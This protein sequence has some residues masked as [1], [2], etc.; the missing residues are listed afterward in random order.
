MEHNVVEIDSR[1]IREKPSTR[2][3]ARLSA[4]R[5]A[6]VEHAAHDAVVRGA[7]E[8]K[9]AELLSLQLVELCREA[10]ALK[11][12]RMHATDARE[13]Q[14]LSTR[15][16]R[17][18]RTIAAATVE[19]HRLENGEPSPAVVAKVLADLQQLVE[20]CMVELFPGDTAERCIGALRARLGPALADIIAGT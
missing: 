3:E 1:R 7:A 10:A 11:W 9:T 18:L 16:I 19:V 6:E 14:R 2:K 8:A 13:R 4:M 12:D 5:D 17:A 15:R 20:G